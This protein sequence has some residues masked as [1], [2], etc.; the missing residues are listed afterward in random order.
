MRQDQYVRMQDL[1]EKLTDVVLDEAAPDQWPGAGVPLQNLDRDTRG[2]RYWCKK[3]AAATLSLVTKIHSLV[4]MIQ[5]ADGDP[6]DP[7]AGPDRDGDL[8]AE[9]R[10]AEKAAEK[11]LAKIAKKGNARSA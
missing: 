4:H 11:L 8:D 3:N 2:D 1:A 5:R 9:M 7:P 10:D 6:S